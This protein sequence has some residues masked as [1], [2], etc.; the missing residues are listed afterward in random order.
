MNKTKL[1]HEKPQVEEY[2]TPATPNLLEA[3]SGE[4][5]VGD[6]TDGG[7]LPTKDRTDFL[8]N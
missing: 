7:E 1:R 6:Y 5:S 4:V 8:G 3:L 2:P